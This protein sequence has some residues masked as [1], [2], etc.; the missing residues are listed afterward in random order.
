MSLLIP[1][2]PSASAGY[3]NTTDLKENKV[4]H[5]YVFKVALDSLRDQGFLV[6]ENIDSMPEAGFILVRGSVKIFDYEAIRDMGENWNELDDFFNPKLSKKE[7]ESRRKS[8]G[9]QRMRQSKVLIDTF[10]KNVIV[11]RLTSTEGYNFTGPLSREHLREDRRNLIYKHG[12][13]PK[14]EWSML[15]EISRL[16]RHRESPEN[17]LQQLTGAQELTG[18]GQ[19]PREEQKRRP[20]EM[21][22]SMVD[23]FDA[24][25]ELIGSASNLDVYVSPVA[26][27]REVYPYEVPQGEQ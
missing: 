25:Q 15:A 16:P 5:N 23:V 27:Y 11:V 17:R 7:K 3:K 9:S 12:S 13:K 4:L 21:L 20:S 18:V 2:S 19:P 1:I 14:G 10:F 24:F 8:A 26:I 22:N 6:E